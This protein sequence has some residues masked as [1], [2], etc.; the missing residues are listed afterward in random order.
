MY[1]Q[2]TKHQTCTR[3]HYCF[4]VVR[5]VGKSRLD[6]VERVES[7]RVEPGGIRVYAAPPLRD[8]AANAVEKEC[9]NYLR[10]TV[11]ELKM[12]S[13]YTRI[14]TVFMKY[15]TTLPLSTPVERL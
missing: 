4:F 1:A 2:S 6:K 12:L 15:N 11:T 13:K 7:C 8:A 5:H 3:K 9:I 10:D 14:K